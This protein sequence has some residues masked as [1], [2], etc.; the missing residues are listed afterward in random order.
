MEKCRKFSESHESDPESDSN[1]V[2]GSSLI[3]KFWLSSS[4]VDSKAYIQL[5]YQNTIFTHNI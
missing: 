1:L 3:S 5:G 4:K 2:V